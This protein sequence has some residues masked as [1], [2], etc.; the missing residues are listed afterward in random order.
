MSLRRRI[1][2]SATLTACF[3]LPLSWYLSLCNRTTS[4]QIEGLEELKAALSEG[5]VLLILWHSRL[6]MGAVHWP[7]DHAPACSLHN[8][9]PLGRIAGAIQRDQGL[10]AMEMSKNKSNLTASRQVIKWFRAGCSVAI[11]ADGP[12]GPAHKLQD[13]P[14]EWASKLNVPVFGYAF[15]T[16]RGRRFNSWD[17]LLLPRLFGRGALVFHRYQGPIPRQP[18]AEDRAKLRASLEQFLDATT[19]RADALLDL[20]PGP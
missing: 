4:W 5:P 11:A 3:G 14:L 9:S 18:D 2:K 1:E 15:S 10:Q 7:S 8:R 19:A 17:H 13:P 6:A 16:T 12:E 20:P